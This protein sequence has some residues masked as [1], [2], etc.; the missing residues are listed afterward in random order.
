LKSCTCQKPKTRG[1]WDPV[2]VGEGVMLRWTATT[3]P[4][5]PVVS[6]STARKSSSA[7]GWTRR[8]RCARAGAGRRTCDQAIWA[9]ATATRERSRRMTAQRLLLSERTA[10]DVEIGGEPRPIAPHGVTRRYRDDGGRRAQARSPSIVVS[11]WWPRYGSSQRRRGRLRRRR[12]RGAAPRGSGWWHAPA[13]FGAPAVS[14]RHVTDRRVITVPPSSRSPGRGDRRL[15][16]AQ[17]PASFDSCRR[18]VAECGCRPEPVR[19]LARPRA[20]RTACAWFSM[21]ARRARS[22]ARF[23]PSSMRARRTIWRL[24]VSLSFVVA[25]PARIRPAQGCLPEE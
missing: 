2:S 6:Q 12:S 8:A 11:P 9:S 7:T 25:R 20:R 4:A 1:L 24:T 17:C 22:S 13:G 23:S 5:R 3:P 10:R 19:R 15:P 14:A 18:L 21:F 16:S